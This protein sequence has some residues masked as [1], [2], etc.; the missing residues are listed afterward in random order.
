MICRFTCH[1]LPLVCQS[2]LNW[3]IENKA[4]KQGFISRESSIFAILSLFSSFFKKI[5][6]RKKSS[7]LYRSHAPALA[8]TCTEI[9]VHLNGKLAKIIHCAVQ[10][11]EFTVFAVLKLAKKAFLKRQNWQNL[12]VF[13]FF[14]FSIVCAWQGERRGYHG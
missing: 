12:A 4:L 8:R 1:Y 3:K 7:I 11:V 5:E 6:K 9:F 14:K 2:F 10:R 13:R